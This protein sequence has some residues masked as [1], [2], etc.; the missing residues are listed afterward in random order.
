M[1]AHYINLVKNN[2]HNAM[3]YFTDFRITKHSFHNWPNQIYLKSIF[4][5]PN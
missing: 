5:S 1:F 2:E 4:V 3:H